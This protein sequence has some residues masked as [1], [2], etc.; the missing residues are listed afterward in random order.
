MPIWSVCQAA[1]YDAKPEIAAVLF[2][3][4]GAAS[5]LPT[6]LRIGT[7]KYRPAK[8]CTELPRYRDWEKHGPSENKR[9]G[10]A[11]QEVQRSSQKQCR[12]WPKRGP[13]GERRSDLVRTVAEG[14]GFEPTLRFPVNTLSQRAPSATRPPLRIAS[15]R[16]AQYSRAGRA[17]KAMSQGTISRDFPRLAAP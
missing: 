13:S 7:R 11:V 17:D 2:D 6:R 1:P 5:E 12:H 14:V 15:S 9:S 4:S 3:R 10:Q 16:S 8:L